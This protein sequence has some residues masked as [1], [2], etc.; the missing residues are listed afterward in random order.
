MPVDIGLVP[1]FLE[2]DSFCNP[3]AV[4]QTLCQ[5]ESHTAQLVSLRY[6]PCTS[7]GRTHVRSVEFFCCIGPLR[8]LLAAPH[9][10]RAVTHQPLISVWQILFSEIVFVLPRRRL[11]VHHKWIMGKKGSR[12]QRAACGTLPT[13]GLGPRP[14]VA[15][16]TPYHVALNKI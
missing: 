7:F 15:M 2:P 12:A 9:A 16:L 13:Q 3:R 10:R 4:L 14:P 5:R 6:L 11:L 8:P 1:P